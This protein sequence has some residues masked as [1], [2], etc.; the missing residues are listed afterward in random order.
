MRTVERQPRNVQR[1]RRFADE[2]VTILFQ[3]CATIRLSKACF[4]PPDGTRVAPSQG[5]DL[6]GPMLFGK[7][8]SARLSLAVLLVFLVC[9][10][11]PLL[12]QNST[13][14][15]HVLPKGQRLGI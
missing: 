11:L 13:E 7:Q 3:D 14:D 6:V 5:A 9:S 15:V 2:K 8:L 1:N 4:G 12:A 10:S